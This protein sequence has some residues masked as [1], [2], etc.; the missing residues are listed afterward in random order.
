MID[1]G[2][3]VRDIE[4]LGEKYNI[5]EIAFDRWVARRYPQRR[6]AAESYARRANRSRWAVSGI[7]CVESSAWLTDNLTIQVTIFRLATGA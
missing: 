5:R 7:V 6:L 2:Y 1:Y 3:I 4:A